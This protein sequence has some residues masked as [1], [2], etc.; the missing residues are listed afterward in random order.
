MKFMVNWRVQDD[1][2][3]EAL[4]IFSGMND[5][6][7][8]SEL[9]DLEMIGRWHDVIGF[10]G[11]AIVETNDPEALSAWL[12]KWN[13][14]VDIE[15]T[16]VLDDKETRDLGRKTIAGLGAASKSSATIGKTKTRP[17]AGFFVLL[18]LIPSARSYCLLGL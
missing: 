3:H 1:R 11:V 16:P 7:A 10:T 13:D 12:L 17:S 18:R 9:G 2:R 6:E 4:K 14:M 15:T 5:E 8:A